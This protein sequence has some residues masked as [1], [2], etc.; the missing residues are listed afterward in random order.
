MS[1]GIRLGVDSVLKNRSKPYVS[2]KLFL[3][4]I[5]KI[6]VPYLIELRD[7]EELEGC[8]AVLLMHN[9]SPH[10]A[11][12]IITV[13]PSVRVRVIQFATH[14]THIFQLLD[15]VLFGAMKKHPIGLD[16]LDKEQPTAAFL[17]KV[18]HDFKQMMIEVNIW[19]AFAAIGLSYD[20]AHNP[21]RATLR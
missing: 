1:R 8:E 2:R 19:G 13:L 20:I 14:T 9:C 5:K 16:T 4:F 17:L 18:Y 3:D 15:V 6:F 21:Y 10:I 12:D 11:D 7:S